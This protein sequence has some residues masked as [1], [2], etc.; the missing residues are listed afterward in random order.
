DDFESSVL[1]SFWTKYANAVFVVFPYTKLAH[2]GAQSVALSSVAN[3][4]QKSIGVYH[5]FASPIYGRASIWVY[6]SGADEL[7]G[8]SIGFHARNLSQ[9]KSASLFTQDYD[10]S[11]SDGGTYYYQLF[12][13]SETPRTSIDRTKA[14]HQFAII[15]SEQ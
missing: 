4:G 10:M 14:W 8:N 11:Q 1:N 13:Q 2:G 5:D 7:S 9:N 3:A 6:D 15:A 12:G